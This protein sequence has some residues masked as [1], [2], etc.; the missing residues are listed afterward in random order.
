VS[1]IYFLIA[2]GVIAAA[3]IPL[4]MKFVPPNRLY[5][6]RTPR[7]LSNREVWF[8]VNHF[9]GWALLVA[10]AMSAS[11]FVLRPE[12]ASGRSFYGLVVFV[13]PLVIAVGA[14]VAYLRKIVNNETGK[15]DDG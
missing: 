12:L 11:I 14:S 7:T 6:F 4:I 8:R 5:G 10:A 15:A 13:V 3:S 2:S 9:A 1:N